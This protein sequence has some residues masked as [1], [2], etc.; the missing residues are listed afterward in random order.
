MRWQEE[1][2]HLELGFGCIWF[3]LA[4]MATYTTAH[5]ESGSGSRSAT[6]PARSIRRTLCKYPDN[7]GR[8]FTLC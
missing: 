6:K 2:A 8:G 4:H 7:G 5:A 1:G 3:D